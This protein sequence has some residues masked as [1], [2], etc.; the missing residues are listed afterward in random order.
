MARPKQAK[1]KKASERISPTKALRLLLPE[2]SAHDAALQLTLA[3]HGKKCRIWC[4]GNPLPLPTDYVAKSLRVVARNEAD[5]R[6]CAEVV[7]SVRE[8]WENRVYNFEFDAEEVRA[9]LPK[10][11]GPAPSAAKPAAPQRR[12][13]GPKIKKNWRLH[14]AAYV[15]D[16]RKKTGQTP[17][18]SEIATYCEVTLD[19]QP[20]E[21][22]IQK[23]VRYLLAD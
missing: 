8:A 2:M 10:A 22:D 23:L 13:P 20:D 12:K 7:S 1:K 9:L 11:E 4:N 18:S 19:Y 16:V 6:W 14:V 5:G 15:H 3:A 21:S 17:P